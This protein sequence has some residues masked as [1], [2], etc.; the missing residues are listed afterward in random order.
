MTFL[1]YRADPRVPFEILEQLIAAGLGDRKQP[2]ITEIEFDRAMGQAS[3]TEIPQPAKKPRARRERLPW[4]R[5]P[6]EPWAVR[7]AKYL[8]GKA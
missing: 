4:R 3:W 8:E 6:F 1:E 7:R 2:H 5:R